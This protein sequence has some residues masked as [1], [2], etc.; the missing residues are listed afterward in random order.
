MRFTD[1]RKNRLSMIA[2]RILPNGNVTILSKLNCLSDVYLRYTP[3]FCYILLH[4]HSQKSNEIDMKLKFHTG[5][6][7]EILV[8]SITLLFLFFKHEQFRK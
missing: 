5:E 1:I 3:S 6:T 7:V 4:F 2:N 8:Y